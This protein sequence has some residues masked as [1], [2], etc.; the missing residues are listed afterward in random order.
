MSY[1]FEY[2]KNDLLFS[3]KLWYSMPQKDR[4]YF[5]LDPKLFERKFE[6][7]KFIGELKVNANKR[8]TIA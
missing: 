6:T 7:S 4:G 2:P 3:Q 1:F 5:A 8:E